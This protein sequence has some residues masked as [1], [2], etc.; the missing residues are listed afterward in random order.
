MAEACDISVRPPAPEGNPGA[1]EISEIV[2][3]AKTVAVIGLSNKPGRESRDVALYLKERG[4]DILPVNPKL[5]EWEGLKCYK[6]ITEVPEGVDIVDIFRRADAI[7]ELVDDI[8][9][10]KPKCVWFQLGIVNNAAAGKNPIPRHSHCS[11]PM[12][13]NRARD[14]SQIM[15][16]RPTLPLLIQLID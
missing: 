14:S 6:S 7:D 1:E 8:V 3:N 11:G 15:P 16:G 2:K 5:T 4:Y 10:R 12:Y 9:S 13:E